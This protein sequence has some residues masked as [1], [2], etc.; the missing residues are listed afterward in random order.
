[1]HGAIEQHG[2]AALAAL[3]AISG[4]S[5]I[6][7]IPGIAELAADRHVSS[8]I[9]S[10]GRHPVSCASASSVMSRD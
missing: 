1:M 6:D 10:G 5:R 4:A 9:R 8:G 2:L 7:P 3:R